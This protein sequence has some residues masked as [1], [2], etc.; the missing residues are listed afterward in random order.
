MVSIK[1][2][3]II[4]VHAF[5]GWMLC[6]MVMFIGPFFL[7]METTLIIHAIL[8]P[9]F[10]IIVSLVYFKKFNY[11]KP[12]TT[13]MMFVAVVILADIFIVS[14]LIEKSFEMFTSF[15]GTWLIFILAFLVV[16][17]TGLMINR[18]NKKFEV[19]ELFIN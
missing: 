13:A 18:K 4:I 3:I 16:W 14:L 10:F 7:S 5:I 8:A 6:G 19:I 9:V 12:L 1:Q 2:F 17:I 15:I 11:T